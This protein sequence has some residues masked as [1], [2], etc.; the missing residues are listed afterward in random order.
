MN[1]FITTLLQFINN[2]DERDTNYNIAYCLI[3]HCHELDKMSVQDLADECYVSVSTFNRFFKLF[4]FKKFVIFKQ[5]IAS[6]VVI[7]LSQMQYRIKLKDYKQVESTLYSFLSSNDYQTVVNASA[8]IIQQCCET[9]LKSKRIVL[10]GS[11]EM[12]SNALRFQGDFCVMKKMTIKDSIYLERF[13]VPNEDDFVIIMTMSGR[14]VD[15]NDDLMEN[16]MARHP[17]ALM[18]GNKDY[19]KENGMFLQIPMGLDEV[20]ENM[21]LDYYLQ[22]IVYTY[23]R[24]YYDC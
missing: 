3:S 11:D 12:I 24:D 7:R 18:I 1:N 22:E 9:I 19:I 6:H 17:K 13:F 8:F 15:L 14:I 10:I 2:P 16:I 23:A 20:L 4:G 5:L 21:I